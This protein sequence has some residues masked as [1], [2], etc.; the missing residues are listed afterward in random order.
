MCA[1]EVDHLAVLLEV[2]EFARPVGAHGEHVDAHRADVVDLLSLVLLDDHLVGYP[3][4]L[5]RAHALVEGL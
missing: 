2:V 1:V 3:E 5:D 4:G